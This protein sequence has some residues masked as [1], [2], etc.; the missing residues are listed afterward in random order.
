MLSRPFGALRR[1][2]RTIFCSRGL[3]RP[4]KPFLDRRALAAFQGPPAAFSE[5]SVLS[6][7]LRALRL[8][9]RRILCSRG[10][11]GPSGCVFGGF[12][13]LAAS[14]GPPAA[15][16]EDSVLSRPLRALR[17]RFRRI[18][19]S[20][21]LSGPSGGV[22]GGSAF[23]ASTGPRNRSWTGVETVCLTT[24]W[25]PPSR[26]PAREWYKYQLSRTHVE[27]GPRSGPNSVQVGR[28]RA[29]PSTCG[30]SRSRAG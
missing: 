5:D 10:L 25:T 6:R 30:R 21:G 4:V 9:F 11:S 15:F 22:F 12:C 2:F 28:S 1:R 27:R 29:G 26:S 3:R 8:R 23:A 17:L 14:Q 18:L 19:C 16:S 20:R 13:A 24:P 7:P